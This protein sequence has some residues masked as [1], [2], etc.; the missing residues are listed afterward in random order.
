MVASP[1]C[2]GWTMSAL[3][4]VLSDFTTRASGYARWI[5]SA[6]ESSSLTKACGGKPVRAVE[7]VGD[8]EQDLARQVA[9]PAPR[10]PSVTSP[11]VALTTSAAPAAAA[12]KVARPTA[13]WS[14]AQAAYSSGRR[15]RR[16]RGCRR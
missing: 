3:F 13:G 11:L 8:V 16:G 4:I 6:S 7:G 2:C 12:A 15:C 14:A 10:M 9:A 5:F 1:S